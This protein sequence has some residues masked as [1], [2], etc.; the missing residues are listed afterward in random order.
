MG[1]KSTQLFFAKKIGD[2]PLQA[3]QTARTVKVLSG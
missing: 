1:G 2:Q 3:R